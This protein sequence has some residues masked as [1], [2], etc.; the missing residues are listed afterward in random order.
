MLG[1]LV[2]QGLTLRPPLSRLALPR[3]VS[4]EKEVDVDRVEA[5]RACSTL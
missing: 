3:D 2:L 4:M 5:A 1:T